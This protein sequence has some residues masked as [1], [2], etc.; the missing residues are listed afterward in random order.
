MRRGERGQA[1]LLLVLGV[2]VVTTSGALALHHTLLRDVALEGEAL[3][4]ARADL[5]ADAV[6]AWFLLEGG[7]LL[8]EE[9]T[10]G[11]L[12]APGGIFVPGPGARE[13]GT[14]VFRRLGPLPEGGG[15]MWKVTLQVRH[16]VLAG[17]RTVAVSAQ[18]REAYVSRAAPA[19]PVLRAWRA[20]RRDI[21]SKRGLE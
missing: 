7:A 17:N 18:E 19:P 15:W 2:L 20:V 6:L 4:G 21:S 10:D 8:T 12:E 14:V 3:R 1:A 9:R 16:R 5:A 13:E 11:S